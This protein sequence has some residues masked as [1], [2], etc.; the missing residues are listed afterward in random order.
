[1][2]SFETSL[3]PLL[4]FFQVIVFWGGG[5][6]FLRVPRSREYDLEDFLELLLLFLGYDL[7]L[8]R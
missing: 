3:I 8:S 1:M 4:P 5:L 2:I 6:E 7:D